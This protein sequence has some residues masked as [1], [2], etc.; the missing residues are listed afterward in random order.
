M[1]IR[2]WGIGASRYEKDSWISFFEVK[3]KYKWKP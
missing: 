3:G 2:E 1:D